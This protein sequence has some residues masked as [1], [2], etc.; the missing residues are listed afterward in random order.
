MECLVEFDSTKSKICKGSVATPSPQ[1]NMP[2]WKKLT[3]EILNDTKGVNLLCKLS[4]YRNS[5]LG[6]VRNKS[7]DLP[8]Y[9]EVF[10]LKGD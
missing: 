10:I 5:S 3:P 7:Y 2:V 6:L 8:T 4:P 1:L 9:D